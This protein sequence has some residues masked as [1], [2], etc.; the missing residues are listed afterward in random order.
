M[1]RPLCS[2]AALLIV[3]STAFGDA[4][5][6]G[7]NGINAT[8]ISLTGAGIGIGQAELYRPGDPTG[9]GDPDLDTVGT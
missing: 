8:G 6:I 1:G 5:S 2:V 4:A 3:A 9:P 7:P